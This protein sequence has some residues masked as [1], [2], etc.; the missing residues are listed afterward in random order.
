[1]SVLSAGVIFKP[2]GNNGRFQLSVKRIPRGMDGTVT[3]GETEA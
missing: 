3:D 1:M 2:S